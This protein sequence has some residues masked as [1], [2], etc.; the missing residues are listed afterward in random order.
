MLFK[1]AAYVPAAHVPEFIL[2]S[3]EV[4]AKPPQFAL[5]QACFETNQESEK[6]RPDNQ[7]LLDGGDGGVD[8]GD[9]GAK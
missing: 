1:C 5:R 3:G 9:D 2:R 4:G 7:R 6:R 8:R